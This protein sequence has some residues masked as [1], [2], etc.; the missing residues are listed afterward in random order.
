MA[1]LMSV[2][3]KDFALKDEAPTLTPPSPRSSRGEGKGEGRRKRSRTCLSIAFGGNK[4]KI[5]RFD[6]AFEAS[7]DR[8]QYC[9]KNF[10]AVP[11]AQHGPAI[12]DDEAIPD[13]IMIAADMLTPVN[14]DNKL[15]LPAGEVGEIGAY[16]KLPH[17]FMAVQPAVTQ[18][19]PE[20]G[21]G[22]I[23]RL[24]QASRSPRC[25]DFWST[26]ALPLTL[27]LSP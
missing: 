26:H 7:F 10:F 11:K 1:G 13:S 17:E 6:T 22:V 18:F 20:R 19:H 16:R 5:M 27:T 23:V 14:F 24:T 8:S 4:S 2:D 21:F 9:F 12:R 15:A 25:L 3:P